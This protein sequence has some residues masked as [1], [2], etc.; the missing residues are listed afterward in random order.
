MKQIKTIKYI[1][2]FK[3]FYIKLKKSKIKLKK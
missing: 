3:I 2:T 1:Y